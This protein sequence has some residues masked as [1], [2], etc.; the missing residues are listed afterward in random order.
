MKRLSVPVL[1]GSLIVLAAGTLT[2]FGQAF[3]ENVTIPA[4]YKTKFVRYTTIDR[5]DNKQSR[6][7]YINPEALAAIKAGR[8]APSGTVIVLEAYRAR[9]DANGDPVKDA[10]G[11]FI[12]DTLAAVNLMEKRTGWG[13]NY[14][15]NLRNGEWEYGAFQPSGQRADARDMTPCLT[16]HLPKQAEDFLFTLTQLKAAN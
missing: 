14:P 1:A 2:A 12:K 6:D 11:R 9:L 7:L 16:C 8:P 4:D 13:V 15:A 5:T 10:N 3:T